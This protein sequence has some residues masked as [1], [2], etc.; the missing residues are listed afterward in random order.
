MS[1]NIYL[2]YFFSI[3]SLFSSLMVIVLSNAVHA[4]LFLILVFCNVSA[5]LLLL[6]AD[7]IALM[8]IIVYVGAIAVLFLFVVMMLNIKQ[9]IVKVNK[10]SIF[11]IGI[12]ILFILANEFFLAVQNF[13]VLKYQEKEISLIHWTSKINLIPTIKAIGNVLYTEY[14]LIFILCGFILLIAMVGAIVLTMHQRMNAKGQS[15][16]IQLSRD[17][18]NVIKFLELRK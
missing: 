7:F 14:S 11:P 18:S 12:L 5:L 10:F 13:D 17:S 6:G 15:I 16:Q 2:F 3:L 8:L 1:L 4:V 9:S